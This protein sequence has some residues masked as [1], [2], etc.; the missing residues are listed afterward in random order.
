MA[1][2]V[3]RVQIKFLIVMPAST[4]KRPVL[5]KQEIAKGLPPV[6]IQV[7]LV[8]NKDAQS[9]GYLTAG[10]VQSRTKPLTACLTAPAGEVES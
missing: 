5:T 2:K 4:I 8:V 10:G 1:L 6:T 3:S 7:A 9:T